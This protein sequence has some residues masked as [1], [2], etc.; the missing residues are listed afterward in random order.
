MEIIIGCK[1]KQYPEDRAQ[2][3]SADHHV[4]RS[5]FA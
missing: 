1:D 5:Y 3:R 4:V 2:C